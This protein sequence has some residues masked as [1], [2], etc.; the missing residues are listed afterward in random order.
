[1]AKKPKTE[2]TVA[3]EANQ[4]TPP[5]AEPVVTETPTTPPPADPDEATSP[6]EGSDE[7]PPA[8]EGPTE[9]DIAKTIAV[10]GLEV[11]AL[12]DYPD[13]AGAVIAC[14]VNY[15]DGSTRWFGDASVEERVK[16]ERLAL[17]EKAGLGADTNEPEADA[18]EQPDPAASDPDA[19]VTEGKLPTRGPLAKKVRCRQYACGWTGIVAEMKVDPRLR[20]HHYCPKCGHSDKISDVEG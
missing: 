12:T 20:K 19:E 14:E 5:A 13:E 18:D 3:P 7:D 8:P 2:E 15:N 1:M 10:D 6:P 17:L 11:V 16:G 4:D 9:E